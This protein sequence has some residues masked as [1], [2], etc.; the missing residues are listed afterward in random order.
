MYNELI[1]GGH[2]CVV[3]V[4]GER[5]FVFGVYENKELAMRRVQEHMELDILSDKD[6]IRY[7]EEIVWQEN[8]SI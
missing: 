2:V 5:S 1:G 3:T 4:I 6:I 8:R 7:S